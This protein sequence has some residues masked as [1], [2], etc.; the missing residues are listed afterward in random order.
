MATFSTYIAWS[1]TA[2]HGWPYWPA[3]A[4]TLLFSFRR[5]L[6]QTIIRP[7]ER[8]SVLRVVIVTIGLLLALQRPDDV[9]LVG[10]GPR[11]R[12]PV[13]HGHVDIGGVT[14]SLQDVGTIVVSLG[15]VGLLWLLFQ[16]TKLGSRCA[17]R[18]PIRPRRASSAS[19]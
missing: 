3:F 10:R 6:H 17:P 12:E 11:R 9:D 16:F 18:P 8:G 7:V 15:A 1:L 2:N 14:V 19:A 4:A 13:P 5:A